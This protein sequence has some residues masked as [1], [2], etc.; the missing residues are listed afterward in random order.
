MVGWVLLAMAFIPRR[1]AWSL[2]RFFNRSKISQD[3]YMPK[4]IYI[5]AWIILALSY[6]I[7]GIDKLNSPSWT[8]GHAFIYL[9]DNPLARDTWLRE[10]LL[11]LPEFCLKAMTYTALGLEILFGIFCIFKK[12]R[13]FAWIAILAMHCAILMIIDFADL[14]FGVLILHLFVFYPKWYSMHVFFVF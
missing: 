4:V 13:F 2:D 12:L 6:T 7:S 8:N 3:W 5:G 14:T 10:W 11:M 9:L 1:E